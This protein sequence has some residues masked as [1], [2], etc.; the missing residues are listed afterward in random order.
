MPNRDGKR[1]L[2]GFEI[3]SLTIQRSEKAAPS[4]DLSLAIQ[5]AWLTGN[6]GR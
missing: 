5:S 2:P 1:G 6:S 3:R 4:P